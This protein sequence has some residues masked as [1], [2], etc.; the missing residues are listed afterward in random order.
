MLPVAYIFIRIFCAISNSS[1]SQVNVM[2]L[3]FT[4]VELRFR[5]WKTT[6]LK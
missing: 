5:G 1:D 6:M 3:K 2:K 4:E